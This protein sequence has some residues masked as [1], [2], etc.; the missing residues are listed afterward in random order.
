LILC[1][2]KIQKVTEK[3]IRK[4]S[5]IVDYGSC[6]KEVRVKVGIRIRIDENGG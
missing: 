3:Y 5:E 6:T 1:Y 2:E 4:F